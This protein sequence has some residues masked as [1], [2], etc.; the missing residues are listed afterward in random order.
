MTRIDASAPP[1]KVQLEDIPVKPGM[2]KECVARAN[3][4]VNVIKTRP[5]RA[6]NLSA[7][8]LLTDHCF[9]S[10]ART[11]GAGRGFG[12]GRPPDE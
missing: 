10:P 8:A 6:T 2:T 3:V 1:R 4:F 11:Q 12:R 9:S 5:S 7:L